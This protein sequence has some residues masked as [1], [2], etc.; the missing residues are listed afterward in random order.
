MADEKATPWQLIETAP[1]DKTF[2]F[3]WR[4]NWGL[5]DLVL[6]DTF[7][8]SWAFGDDDNR[9]PSPSIRGRRTG[10][11]FRRC[12]KTGPNILDGGS[13]NG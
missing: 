5:P 12:P 7:H 1:K 9:I 6:W 11:P 8:G 2:I 13:A 4:K 3:A 10:C